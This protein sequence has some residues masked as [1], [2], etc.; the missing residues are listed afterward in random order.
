MSIHTM[1]HPFRFSMHTAVNPLHYI[2]RR[3][4]PLALLWL[5]LASLTACG[6][7][8]GSDGGSAATTLPPVA[9]NGAVTTLEDSS[10]NATLNASDPSGLTLTFR[11]VTNPGKGAVVVNA[12]GSFTYT[13]NPNAN[14]SDSFTFVANNGSSDSN[15]ATITITITP[16]ADRPVAVNDIYTVPGSGLSLTI[17]EPNCSDPDPNTRGV[18]CNDT[19]PDGP[20]P[21]VAKLSTGVSHGT[22]SLN[23]NGSFSY[24]HNCDTATSDSFTYHAN[25]GV[26]D[27]AATATVTLSINQPP[28]AD[29]ACVS[30]LINTPI[31]GALSATDPEGQPVTYAFGT[32]GGKGTVN[33]DA[34]GNYSYTP[35]MNLRGMDKFTYT[36]TDS[37]GAQATGTATVLI[38]G[39]VR[40]MPLGDSITAGSFSLPSLPFS[41]QV[42]YRRKLFLDLEAL[43]PDYGIDFVGSSSNGSADHDKDNEGHGGYCATGPCGGFAVIDT[44]TVGW[45]NA[46]PA[47]I[48]L[49][50]IGITDI[51]VRGDTS[52]TG[53]TN[54]LNAIDTWE[55][56]NHPVTVLLAKIIDDVPNY[57]KELDV[58]A[59]NNSLVNMLAGR[60]NDR[61]ILVDM[62]DGAGVLYGDGS[63]GP[64]MY[65]NVHPNL[66]GYEKMAAKWLTELTNPANV[67]PKY[68]GLPQCSP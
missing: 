52:A 2:V 66:S 53:V 60:P 62:R 7:G 25:D 36:V 27:S 21:T 49:L 22:L 3:F 42:G 40:I 61:V 20:A 30:T 47:D 65:D 38:D 59:Y 8:G 19:D 44:N 46:N 17:S 9:S 1:R 24:T 68:P 54:I 16:V 13:P 5:I 34:N 29:N 18:L 11:K 33:I 37:L 10:V 14:G 23:A 58:T 35:N 64:D 57:Q 15:V 50:H 51:N 26:F 55:A 32:H 48:V 12:N 4:V 41:E 63:P 31:D 6:G 56:A 28:A 45:L 67:G 43:S 39:K